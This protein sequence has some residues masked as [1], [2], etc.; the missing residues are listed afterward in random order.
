MSQVPETI[1]KRTGPAHAGNGSRNVPRV[2]V[3]ST[4]FP[5][6]TG[7]A[8]WVCDRLARAGVEPMNGVASE[9][10]R[11]IDELAQT[12]EALVVVLVD[13]P[14]AALA[15]PRAGDRSVESMLAAWCDG[16][17]R[18]LKLAHRRPRQWLFVDAG[19]A[20]SSPGHFVAALAQLE[21]V[22]GLN[23]PADVDVDL[24]TKTDPVA[25]VI[26]AAIV[27]DHTPATALYE[28]L[29]ASCIAL[30]SGT[31]S[32]QPDA[33]SALARYRQLVSRLDAMT[34]QLRQSDSDL[35]GA[36]GWR[37]ERDAAIAERTHLLLAL[38]QVQDE[39]ER[40]AARA[41]DAPHGTLGGDSSAEL[42]IVDVADSPP[43]R[44]LRCELQGF[45]LSGRSVELAEVRL[46]EHRLKPG[47][48]LFRQP[49]GE[50]LLS[51][52]QP[53][54]EEDGRDFM[55]LIPGD[56]QGR[57]H[58]E[59]LAASD[60]RTVKAVARLLKESVASSA[61]ATPHWK[62]V[63]ARLSLQLDSLP[64]R[65]RYDSAEAAHE[66]HDRSVMLVRFGNVTFGDR[67]LAAVELRWRHSA[68]VL[69]WVAP[70][71]SDCLPFG[72]WPVSESG[73]PMPSWRLPVGAGTS[74]AKRRQWEALQSAE[75][76]LVLGLLEALP[77]AGAADLAAPAAALHREARRA[78]SGLTVRHVA[79]RLLGRAA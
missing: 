63:A 27:R 70:A 41:G 8:T 18:M 73:L 74:T 55:L 12:P 45:K 56:A 1:A 58:L 23:V 7:L 9:A 77:N 39:F 34:E 61:A 6:H 67:N 21:P 48:A 78:L 20:L 62:T 36:R 3:V 14:A 38:H 51:T 10:W 17:R 75:R 28:E 54:G 44:H 47:L 57:R 37:D 35:Q 46:V 4:P 79:R 60:W 31:S 19:E 16:V 49:R 65:F 40:F 11:R 30:D 66:E 15:Q 64:L 53:D 13:N 71:A 29:R 2:H 72:A 33:Q 50:A 5:V 42:R 59:Q 32:G 26:V 76:Q 43:H 52:W 24:T 25:E 69:E 68:G 22:H